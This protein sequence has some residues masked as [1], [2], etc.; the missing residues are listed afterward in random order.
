MLT[1]EEHF[2]KSCELRSEFWQSV[3]EL[4]PDVI[5]HLINPS[6]MGGP[7]WPSL[8]QAFATIRRPDVTIIASDGLSDPY[9]E[10]DND[11]NGLGMEVYVETTPIEGSVQNTWQFQLAYQAAQLM[12]EQGNVISL[13]EELTYITTEFYDVDVPFKTER[14]TVGAILGLPSTRFNNEVTLSLEAVK[15]VNIKLLTLA[16]LDYILQHGD[17]GRVKVAE[18]LIKQGDATLSTLERPSVI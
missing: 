17:E 9:E 13:L 16:E 2:D 12:A 15:M 14:G 18:L 3:G 5:A 7:V 6:F 10:G 1:Y 8:R 4:D 11:Y